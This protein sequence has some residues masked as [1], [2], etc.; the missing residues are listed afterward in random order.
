MLFRSG[1]FINPGQVFAFLPGSR[2]GDY[3]RSCEMLRDEASA[4][5]I[6][7]PAHADIN[8]KTFALP[9]MKMDDVYALQK[10]LEAM[11]E[12]RASAQGFFPREYYVNSTVSL[13]TPFSWNMQW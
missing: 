12:G 11:K 8:A 5:S 4:V 10:T 9:K 6:L 3:L 13:L 7:F 2:V 1:D